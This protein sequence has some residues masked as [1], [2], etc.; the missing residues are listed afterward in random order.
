MEKENTL[1]QKDM[2]EQEKPAEQNERHLKAVSEEQ[3]QVKELLRRGSVRHYFLGPENIWTQE[4]F[5]IVVGGFWLY[6]LEDSSFRG[7]F[8][9]PLPACL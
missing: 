6:F 9:I 5:G 3:E 4:G 2:I 7:F 1:K 8:C